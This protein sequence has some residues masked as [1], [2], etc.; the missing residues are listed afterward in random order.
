MTD[1]DPGR[2]KTKGGAMGSRSVPSEGRRRSSG[3]GILV[4]VLA[5]ALTLLALAPSGVGAQ[6][7]V[8]EAECEAAV[9]ATAQAYESGR[10]PDPE[11]EQLARDCTTPVSEGPIGETKV[12]T[13]KSGLRGTSCKT[14]HAGYGYVNGFGIVFASLVGHL[15]WCY[16]GNKVQGGDF[17]ITPDS[18]CFWFYEGVVHST[19]QGCFG[20]CAY[21]YRHRMGSFFFNPPWPAVTT[22]VQP[23]FQMYANKYGGW[24]KNSGG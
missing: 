13:T 17:W 10:T 2:G 18:C 23:W 4:R 7:P 16:N 22:R 8:S 1:G 9:R 11:T 24:W 21:V 15:S 14:I 12:T 5:S 19:N 20:G 3:K 6:E